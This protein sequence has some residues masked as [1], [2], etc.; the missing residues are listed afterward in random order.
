MK[1]NLLTMV[2][3]TLLAGPMAANAIPVIWN[4]DGVTFS[5]G[6]TANGSFTYDADLNAYTDINITTGLSANGTLGTTYG[7]RTPSASSTFFSVVEALPV[8]GHQRLLFDLLQPMTNAGG[9]IGINLGAPNVADV[10]GICIN[11]LCN[12]VGPF[13]TITAGSIRSVPEPGTLALFGLGLAGLGFARRRR[14]AN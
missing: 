14:A 5:D 7:V 1:K 6:R 11:T 3:V 4:L 13:R 2:A 8:L 10:D 12:L 9:I